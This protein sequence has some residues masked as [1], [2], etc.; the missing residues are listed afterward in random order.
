MGPG[1]LRGQVGNVTGEVI[2]ECVRTQEMTEDDDDFA[3]TRPE[4]AE[5]SRAFSQLP[6]P[7]A[8]SRW[9]S[10]LLD[11]FEYRDQ[12]RRGPAPLI[13]KKGH[14]DDDLPTQHTFNTK[15]NLIG[16]R[17]TKFCP[18]SHVPE[19]RPDRSLLSRTEIANIPAPR[20]IRWIKELSPTRSHRPGG[21][22][23]LRDGPGAHP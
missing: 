9:R 15:L 23:S 5:S 8:S 14:T 6:N 13:T 18:W 19:P 17:L 7:P 2:T 16:Y 11:C 12:S 3:W 4:Q 20:I 10:Q 21:A 1:A 22:T